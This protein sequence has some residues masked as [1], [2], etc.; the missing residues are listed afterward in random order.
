[1]GIVPS[2]GE[3]LWTGASTATLRS[4][5]SSRAPTLPE[6][7]SSISCFGRRPLGLLVD[8][9]CGV[10]AVVLVAR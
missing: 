6:A 7:V 4:S 9:R 10:V 2:F 5:S 1:L 3:E 8:E